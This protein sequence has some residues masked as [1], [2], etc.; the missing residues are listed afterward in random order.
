METKQNLNQLEIE[1]EIDMM[2]P[3]VSVT[4]KYYELEIET[5]QDK[6]FSLRYKFLSRD[7]SEWILK[8]N[9]YVREWK[10]IK[11]VKKYIK[12]KLKHMTE[13]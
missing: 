8:D 12:T 1:S 10:T 2:Q 5:N 13:Q 7:I 6:T 11:G 3:D 4:F 9:N